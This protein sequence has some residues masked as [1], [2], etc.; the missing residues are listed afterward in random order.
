MLLL[1]INSKTLLKSKL[2]SHV[3]Y[4]P[5][6]YLQPKYVYSSYK[7]L[8]Q[9]IIKNNQNHNHKYKNNNHKKQ[10]NNH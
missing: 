7:I 1:K 5:E 10:N 8:S 6:S 9:L 3:M 4:M 2:S